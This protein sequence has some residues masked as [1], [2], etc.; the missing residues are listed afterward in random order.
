MRGSK[1]FY[2]K[3]EEEN[4]KDFHNNQTKSKKLERLMDT[5]A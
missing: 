1:T 5:E 3:L 4:A 2:D